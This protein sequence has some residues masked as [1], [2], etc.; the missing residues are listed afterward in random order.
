MASPVRVS[1]DEV[2]DIYNREN[3]TAAIEYI[4]L[5]PSYFSETLNPTEVELD[6]WAKSNQLDIKQ[7][8]ETNKFKYTNLEKMAR[9][10]HILIKVD[11]DA[12]E[13]KKKA[14]R[15][16]IDKHDPEKPAFLRKIMD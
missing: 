1:T 5:V 16:K 7:Y 12:D 9:A 15:E 2:R 13:A 14:A 3:N 10:R 11:D 8:Y 6:V 4:K